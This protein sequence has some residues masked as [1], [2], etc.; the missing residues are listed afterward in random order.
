M[1]VAV[2]GAGSIG[3]GW[4]VVF[5]RAGLEVSLTDPDAARL[6][7]VPADLVGRLERLAAGGLL[8]ERPADVA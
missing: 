6:R 5:A 2:V 1:R 7:A 4:T 8:A 3:V